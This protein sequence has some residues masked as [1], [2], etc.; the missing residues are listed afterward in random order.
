MAKTLPNIV[1]LW[2]P[3]MVFCFLASFEFL[4]PK[5]FVKTM[6]NENGAVEI[7]QF[8][9]IAAAF[10]VYIACFAT[11][12][13]Q[14]LALSSWVGIAALSCLYIA[15]EEVSWGQHFWN[16]STPEYWAALNDQGETNFHNT[17]SWLD[18]KPR[19]VLEIGV[20]IGGLIIPCLL[21]FKPHVL[22]RQFTM[23][24]PPAILS[25]TAAIALLINVADKIDDYNPVE[26]FTRTSEAEELYLF[27]FVLLYGV[28][29]YRRI[30]QDKR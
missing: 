24:Y 25:V 30:M 15:G 2:I 28:I 23:I 1:W 5:D 10:F 17:S 14:S 19:L 8:L 13:T 20:I 22:P 4:E 27:Y 16:W 11:I 6:Y 21:R 12:K 29:L 7:A 18:Q 26:L 3:V 9:F